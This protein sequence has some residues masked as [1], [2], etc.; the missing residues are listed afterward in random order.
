[1]HSNNFQDLMMLR[2]ESSREEQEEKLFINIACSSRMKEKISMSLHSVV[3]QIKN[4][5]LR[6]KKKLLKLF[7]LLNLL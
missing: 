1:M 4:T 3:I 5:F 2:L 6:S 7:L